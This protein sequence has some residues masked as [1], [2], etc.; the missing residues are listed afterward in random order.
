MQLHR[1]KQ[2]KLGDNDA[3]SPAE[4]SCDL[5][6]NVVFLLEYIGQPAR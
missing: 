2:A 4:T 5:N 1:L 6:I 3:I